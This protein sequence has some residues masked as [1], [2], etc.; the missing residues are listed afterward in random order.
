MQR[1]TTAD[2]TFEDGTGYGGG[3]TTPP[4]TPPPPATPPPTAAPKKTWDYGQ[5]KSWNGGW[6]GGTP[7]QLRQWVESNPYAEGVTIGGTH[8]DKLFFPGGGG[9]DAIIGAAGGGTQYGWTELGGSG[10][11]GGGGASGGGS[12]MTGTGSG[13]GGSSSYSGFGLSDQRGKVNSLYDTLLQRAQQ[14]L[15]IDRNDPIIRAQSD[16]YGAQQ[17]RARRNFLSDMAERGSPYATGA[18]LGQQ[19][20]TAEKMGGDLGAF[21]AQLMGRELL[22]RR[23]Q[24]QSSLDSMKDML[25]FDQK[26]A[27][28]KELAN[29][30]AATRRYGFDVDAAT[31]RYGIDTGAQ[32]ARDRLGFDIGDREAYWDYQWNSR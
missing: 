25:S 4:P 5:F 15:N 29:L 31:S 14:S 7:E 12:G 1:A 21:E 23:E 9:V 13:I 3:G 19:R 30:D 17:E 20:M 28:E 18:Q 10:G 2:D 26:L 32:T 6:G 16:A 11:G 24:I 27:L 22:S 8:G